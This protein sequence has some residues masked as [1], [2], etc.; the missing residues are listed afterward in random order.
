MV[1]PEDFGWPQDIGA[2]GILDGSRL[3]ERM[4]VSRSRSTERFAEWFTDQWAGRTP[5]TSCS[6]WPATTHPPLQR[7]PLTS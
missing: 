6:R 4:A 1:W 2:L 3:L 5:S 7:R